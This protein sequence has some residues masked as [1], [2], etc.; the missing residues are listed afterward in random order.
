M[1]VDDIAF[2]VTVTEYCSSWRT[3]SPLRLSL[4]LNMGKAF[5]SSCIPR[6]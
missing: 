2:E 4:F 5:M 1:D 6:K 3:F